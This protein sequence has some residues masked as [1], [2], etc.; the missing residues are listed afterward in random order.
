MDLVTKY[1]IYTNKTGVITF[2]SCCDLGEEYQE[3]L[4][5]ELVK[6][7]YFRANEYERRMQ[8]GMEHSQEMRWEYNTGQLSDLSFHA[9][10]P[11]KMLSC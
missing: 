2:W 8:K 11:N 7:E 4:N 9:T 10:T 1:I 3:P 5:S 6:W